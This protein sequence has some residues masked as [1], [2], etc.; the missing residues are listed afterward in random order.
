MRSLVFAVS[1]AV[2]A[3]GAAAQADYPEKPI[4]LVV[5][6]PPGSTLDIAARLISP[7][8]GDALGKPVVVENVAGAAGGLAADRAAKAPPDGYTLAL[9]ASAQLVVNPQPVQ[10]VV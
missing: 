7:K 9:A 1:C 8:L 3:G 2:T 5:G 10:A 6:F 4:R